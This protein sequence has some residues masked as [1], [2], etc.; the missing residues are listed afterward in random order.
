M[1][2]RR[3]EGVYFLANDRVFDLAV[4]FL[5]SFRKHNPSIP[6]CMIP[7]GGSTRRLKALCETYRF[8]IYD[9]RRV[10]ETCDRIGRKLHGKRVGEYRKLAIWKG[11][12]D[13][14][15]YF[16]VDTVVLS[17]V[18][19]V[20]ALLKI[21][22]FIASHSNVPRNFRYV[23]RKSVRKLGV[24]ADWQIRYSGA[25][26]FIASRKDSNFYERARKA[27]PG[28][29][30]LAKHMA[31]E[32]TD[33]PFMNYIVVT[34]GLRISSLSMIAAQNPGL[35]IPVEKWAGAP[36]GKA[37]AGRPEK[38]SSARVLFVHWAGMWVRGCH[39]RSPL[40]RY[41]RELPVDSG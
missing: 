8:D 1:G 39:L 21:Y 27:L 29:L 26:G 11:E 31:L 25:M 17:D 16:D 3:G 22:D 36:L 19:F 7:F 18:R 35:R 23:W 38:A 41:Y 40:W 2:R 34:S 9:N 6:L 12:F 33:Q 15:A 13:S 24:L 5:N 28:A 32:K 30:P 20:F 37:L 10:L 4:A 14:F